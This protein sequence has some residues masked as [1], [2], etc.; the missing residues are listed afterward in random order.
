MKGELFAHNQLLLCQVTP[1][2]ATGCA[3]L[4]TYNM[5]IWK[6]G[7]SSKWHVGHFIFMCLGPNCLLE[8]VP[9]KHR[10]GK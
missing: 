7:R 3:Q 1:I 10:S 8:K 9:G 6:C 2:V 4:D 5:Y